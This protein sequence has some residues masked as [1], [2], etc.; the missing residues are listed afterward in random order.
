MLEV[1]C[2]Q[3]ASGGF[4]VQSSHCSGQ[5]EF[6]TSTA[7]GQKNGQSNQKRNKVKPL[8]AAAAQTA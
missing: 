7:D 2:L 8:A 1:R 3:S 5:A 6:D 4:D